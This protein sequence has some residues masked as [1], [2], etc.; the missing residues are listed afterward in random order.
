M[1]DNPIIPSTPPTRKPKTMT[2]RD[3]MDDLWAAIDSVPDAPELEH[4]SGR[5]IEQL[6]IELDQAAVVLRN[7]ADN[8]AHNARAVLDPDSIHNREQTQ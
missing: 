2:I 1:S 8:Y 4:Q 3:T 7:A 6:G 5:E